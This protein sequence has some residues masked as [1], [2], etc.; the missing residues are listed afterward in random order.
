MELRVKK[1][2]ISCKTLGE[3]IGA[4]E[5]TVANWLNRPN[6]DEVKKQRILIAIEEIKGGKLNV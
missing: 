3:K 5:N 2:N 1:G 6:L 4:H